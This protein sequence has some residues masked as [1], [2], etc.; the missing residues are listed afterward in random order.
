VAIGWNDNNAVGCRYS[1]IRGQADNIFDAVEMLEYLNNGKFLTHRI[2]YY[3]LNND[4]T[5]N[6]FDVFALIDEIFI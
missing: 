3:N 2:N 6:L 5:I 1:Y 4:A